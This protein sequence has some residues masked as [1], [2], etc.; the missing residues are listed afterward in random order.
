[1]RKPDQATDQ[2]AAPADSA[3]RYRQIRSTTSLPLA[4]F[5]RNLSAH[6]VSTFSA[7][8]ARAASGRHRIV[9]SCLNCVQ[10]SGRSGWG[11]F[12]MYAIKKVALL[13]TATQK[14]N[15]SQ[16]YNVRKVFS[17]TPFRPLAV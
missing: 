9:V 13:V 10:P 3:S 4:L 5:C 15:L 6:R 16:M 14:F 7:T 11:D 1:M 17:S 12:Y 2:G 8:A